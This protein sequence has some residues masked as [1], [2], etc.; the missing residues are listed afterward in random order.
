MR[1][2][3][4]LMATATFT[5]AGQPKSIHYKSLDG[6]IITADYYFVD[7]E[8]PLIILFHQAGWSRGE[9]REIAP[10]LNTLGFNCLAVDQRSGKEVNGVV[11]ETHQR[12]EKAGKKTEYLDAYQDMQ[13]SLD[14]AADSL[15]AK[16]II[17]W[18]SSYSSALNFVLTANNLDKISAMLSFAPGEYFE[19]FG[20]P[21]NYIQSHAAK[22]TVPI[23][24]TSKRNEYENWQ[25]IFEAVPARMKAYF[26]PKISGQ[27]GSRALW[28]KF[29]EH[30]DYW[31]VV[32]QFLQETQAG[33]GLGHF[34]NP[35]KNR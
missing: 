27:H 11:N 17:S 7:N 5:F 30:K 20:K 23:F 22:I 32:T 4:L 2:F 12:A 1:T 35:M 34:N 31:K 18:G 6:L 29:P 21:A 28:E 16:K 19:R 13:A 3:L 26:L 33:F 9:Y 10:K 24:V 8:A 25:A 15:K 14:Y